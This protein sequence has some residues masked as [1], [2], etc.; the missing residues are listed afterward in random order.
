MTDTGW[1]PAS[2]YIRPAY[3]T[4]PEIHVVDRIAPNLGVLR[5]A[6]WRRARERALAMWAAGGLTFLVAESYA[7]F[8]DDTITV[9]RADVPDP[10]EAWAAWQ[11]P[12]CPE[13]S[14]NCG[15]VQLDRV[16][17]RQVWRAR[18]LLRMKYL[19]A[20]EIGHCLGFGH[21]GTGV[22]AARWTSNT[23]NAEELSALRAYWGTDG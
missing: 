1:Y 15:W 4:A 21:G 5:Q 7:V 17:W 9:V 3:S 6:W 2:Y 10:I 23:V 16:A 13:G 11:Q 12:P 14:H 22:M 20:H 8:Q 18:N 19:I